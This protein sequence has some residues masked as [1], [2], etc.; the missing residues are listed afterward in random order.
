[1]NRSLRWVSLPSTTTEQLSRPP[2][3]RTARL[4]STAV[5]TSA[6]LSLPPDQTTPARIASLDPN[7]TLYSNS[8]IS[9]Y[10]Y[11]MPAMALLVGHG[12]A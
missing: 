12:L 7:S 11:R 2:R 3:L 4:T 1:M 5:T 8:K 9:I 6:R 10:R